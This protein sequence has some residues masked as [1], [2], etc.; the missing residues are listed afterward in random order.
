MWGSGWR[1]RVWS[2]IKQP[3]DI[4]VLLEKDKFASCALAP[5]MR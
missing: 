4:I 2:Q 5:K 1:E 3:W